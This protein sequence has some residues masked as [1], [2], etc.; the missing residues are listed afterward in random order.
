MRKL[1]YKEVGK[2]IRYER[3]SLGLTRE[4]FA[5]YLNLSTNFVGQIERGEKKDG[6]RD[7]N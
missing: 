3:E 4:R 5:E 7:L 2:K 6:I 1:N